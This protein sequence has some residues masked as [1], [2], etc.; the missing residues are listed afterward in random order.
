MNEIIEGGAAPTPAKTALQQLAEQAALLKQKEAIAQ[1]EQA[2]AEARQKKLAAQ[3]PA[4]SASPTGGAVSTDEQFGYLAQLVAYDTLRKQAAAVAEQ[5]KKL[6][7]A[8]PVKILI[9]DDLDLA[10]GDVQLLQVHH[11]LNAL[12]RALQAQIEANEALFPALSEAAPLQPKGAA[13]MALPAF[14]ALPAALAALPAA[15]GLVGDITSLFQVDYELKGQSFSLSNTAFA[16]LVAGKLAAW[17]VYLPNFF[18]LAASPLLDTLEAVMQDHWQ[19]KA[20]VQRLRQQIIV[21]GQQ[22]AARLKAEIETLAKAAAP[23]AGEAEAEP[24]D[25]LILAARRQELARLESEQTTAAAVLLQSENLITAFHESR[26]ALTTVPEGQPA[27]A[28]AAAILREKLE[29]EGITH[30][31]Y[32]SVVSSGG[33]AIVSKRRFTSG[34]TAYLGGS[35]VSYILAG[36]DGA[37]I[38]AD[39]RIEAGRMNYKLG[40][41]AMPAFEEQASKNR[42]GG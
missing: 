29:T 28:L 3:L 22:E 31:L 14:T 8:G 32:L 35:V 39:T 6:P 25:S 38:A 16:A 36:V 19:L 40:D 23:P 41:K 7:L 2:I 10:G 11:Q 27:S 9:V 21:P 34:N 15:L 20:Q 24:P 42:P 33:E 17:P 5:I 13:A 4:A 30:L 37:I 26:Q 12:R 1:S 18:R